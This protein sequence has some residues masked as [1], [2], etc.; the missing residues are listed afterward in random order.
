MDLKRLVLA[1]V[2]LIILIIGCVGGAKPAEN[3]TAKTLDQAIKEAAER[4]D[5]RLDSGIKIALLNFDSP[6]DGFLEYVLDELTAN[7]VDSGKLTVVDR[8]EIDLIRIEFE[9]QYSGDV[10]DDSMQTLGRMLGAQSIVSGSLTSIGGSYRLVIR[11]LNV[12]SA[13]V[14]VQYRADILNDN[15]VQ[16]LLAIGRSDASVGQTDTTPFGFLGVNLRDP[17]DEIRAALRLSG[18]KGA[19]V[20][21]IFLNSPADKGGIR[22]GDFITYINR[23]EATDTDRLVAMV[24]GLRVGEKAVFNVI[25]DGASRDI[26]VFIEARTDQSSVNSKLWPGVYVVPLTDALRESAKLNK[27][28]NGVYAGQVFTESPA[29]VIGLQQGDIIIAL[30]GEPINDLVAYYGQLRETERELW[31]T[32]IRNNATLNSLKFKK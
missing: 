18:R 6:S 24:G 17:P 31:F 4:I 25:R 26:E 32:Y 20:S 7:L 12:Q 13:A 3:S 23:R 27:N 2:P 11:V 16:A 9:F 1:I 22:P 29:A 15:R 19:F 28:T 21:G 30:S 14:E 8:R 5:G 10:D